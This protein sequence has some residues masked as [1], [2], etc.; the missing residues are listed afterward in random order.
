MI[1]MWALEAWGFL[2]MT[3]ISRN[4]YVVNDSLFLTTYYHMCV[5]NVYFANLILW[6]MWCV[7]K[8]FQIIPDRN[9]TNFDCDKLGNRLLFLSPLVKK[10][11]QNSSNVTW[12][13]SN[14]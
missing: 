11:D 9:S 6:R 3:E 10:L 7:I 13:I 12:Y 2:F 8:Y 1:K 14:L 5:E 4:L